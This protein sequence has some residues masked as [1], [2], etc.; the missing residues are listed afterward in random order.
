MKRR[1]IKANQSMMACA[2]ARRNKREGGAKKRQRRNE[3]V[4]GEVSSNG[5]R[6][7]GA[8]YDVKTIMAKS[9]KR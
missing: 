6:Q 1:A 8:S 2:K 7:L 3:E 9:Q 4:S 5:S